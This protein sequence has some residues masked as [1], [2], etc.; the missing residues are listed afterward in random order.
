VQA[1]DAASQTFRINSLT[2]NYQN[3]AVGGVL[4]DGA[5]VVVQGAKVAPGGALIANQ[6]DLTQVVN[7]QPGFDGRLEG[8]ITSLSSS[9]YF[10]VEGQP[11]AVDAHTKLHLKTP[12][13]LD[14]EVEVTGT[15]DANGVLVA[16]KV[17]SSK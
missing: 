5:D 2:V 6:V 14:V 13:A 11:V 17:Q 15:F 10:E 16:S 1:L 7:N 8:L 9:S 12:L 3:A 4:V